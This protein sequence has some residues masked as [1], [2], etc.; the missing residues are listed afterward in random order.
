[1]VI[2]ADVLVALNL[3]I[4]FF[5]LRGTALLLRRG[6][7]RKRLVLSAFIGALGALIILAPELHFAISAVYKIALGAAMTF[8]AFGKQKP[9]DFTICALFFLVVNFIFAGVINA[10]WVFFA[11]AGMLYENGIF[12]FNIPI[13]ALIAFTAAA[14]FLIKLIKL[15]SKKLNRKDK[16]CE[17]KIAANN[18][19]VS[20]NGL[21]DT[22]CNAEDLFSK[23]PVIICEYYKITKIIPP[24]IEKYFSSLSVEKIRLVPLST[25]SGDTLMPIFRAQSILIN[26]K[27]ADALIGV[28]KTKLGMDIDCIFNPEIISL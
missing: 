3:Y 20:L 13:V 26:G 9:L 23:T 4:N 22:G 11:P 18:T 7:S 10:L 27:P 19:E 16:I 21:C 14:F 25:A 2:Y 15:I 5:L 24:D 1:M 8:V 17:V 6:V 28:T 12:Y